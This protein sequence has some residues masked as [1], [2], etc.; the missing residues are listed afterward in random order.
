MNVCSRFHPIVVKTLGVQ[1]RQ[2]S[3]SGDH[4]CHSVTYISLD[5][6][7]DLI[8]RQ[9]VAQLQILISSFKS[10]SILRL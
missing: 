1:K 4:E 5:Q 9:T 2:N 7:S 6:S 8:D 10:N 3:C